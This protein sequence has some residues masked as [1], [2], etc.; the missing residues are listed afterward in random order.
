MPKGSEPVMR[1]KA[2]VSKSISGHKLQRANT[3][4]HG[5]LQ[6]ALLSP[7]PQSREHQWKNGEYRQKEQSTHT[8]IR[9]KQS[10]E[11]K[12]G[13]QITDTP[14]GTAGRYEHR[15]AI[16]DWCFRGFALP[17]LQE[18]F[19]LWSSAGGNEDKY[20]QRLQ[21]NNGKNTVGGLVLGGF[22]VSGFFLFCL[23]IFK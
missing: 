12:G 19:H 18:H 20:T 5:S 6:P 13:G 10:G 3:H 21:N 11:K 22:W 7:A 17:S 4:P 23:K 8:D 1:Q 14:S 9:E 16:G 2:N 15:Q